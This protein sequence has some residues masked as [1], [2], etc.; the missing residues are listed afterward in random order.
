MISEAETLAPYCRRVLPICSYSL[1]RPIPAIP[2]HC[3]F[4]RQSSNKKIKCRLISVFKIILDLLQN[5]TDSLRT[6]G[7]PRFP[8]DFPPPI[9][10]A[11]PRPR[12]AQVVP[13]LD[14]GGSESE[15]ARSQGNAESD[16]GHAC[17]ALRKELQ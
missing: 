10:P 15:P 17:A 14:P 16:I 12:F 2:G 9:R 5:H 4:S 11:R 1:T 3:L 8:A 7:V 13:F 6:I